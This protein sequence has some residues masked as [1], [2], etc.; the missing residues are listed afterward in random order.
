MSFSFLRGSENP[1]DYST[2]T[3]LASACAR[4]YVDKDGAPGPHTTTIQTYH[5]PKN[6][7][8]GAGFTIGRSLYYVDSKA[9]VFAVGTYSNTTLIPTLPAYLG[10]ADQV[11]TAAESARHAAYQANCGSSPDE[12]SQ[13]FRRASR[14]N[15]AE[16]KAIPGTECTVLAQKLR[17]AVTLVGCPIEN[18][19]QKRDTA[20]LTPASA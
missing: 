11:I 3:N 12:I 17:H 9:N 18:N 1:S 13:D 6:E 8:V 14:L 2:E 10:K 19:E 15:E 20:N 4:H 7:T 5:N 16:I